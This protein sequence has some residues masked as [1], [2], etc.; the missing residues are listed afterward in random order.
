MA[1]RNKAH[2]SLALI[3]A[4]T[5]AL[6]AFGGSALAE[7]DQTLDDYEEIIGTY[8]IDDSIPSYETYVGRH[9]GAFPDEEI[10]IE[11]KDY[12]RYLDGTTDASGNDVEAIPEI[13]TN[14]EPDPDNEA[15]VSG[16]AV[17]T[18]EQ[19]LI[20][21]EVTINKTG[22]YYLSVNYIPV[23]GASA[24][25]QRA[26]FIDGEL[27]Y[28][29]CASVEFDRVYQCEIKDGYTD[30][31]GVEL[32][33]WEADNQGNDLKPALIETPE[34]IDSYLYDSEGYVT[35]EL[36]F[37]LEAGTHTITVVALRE[38][39]M[40]RQMKLG[41][42]D[43]VPT[44]AEK[45]KEWEAAGA[46]DAS[47]QTIRI[48]AENATKTSSQM[49][50][51]VQD[52]SS[53]A[54]YPS[55]A[56]E[57]KNNS[58]GGNSWRLTGQWI[59]WE[60]DVEQ[61]GFYNIQLFDKQNFVR[62][63]YVSRKITIDGEVP[64]EEFSDYGFTYAQSW[65]LD[66]LE[67]ENGD[68]YK[69][70]LEEGHH[71][72]RMEVVLGEFS[73]IISDVQDI[74]TDLNSVYRSVI[75]ITGVAPDADRDYQIESSLPGL[76][77][78]LIDLQE[79]L[80]DV[81]T[82][83]RAVAGK[84][85]DKE[86]VLITMRDELEELSKD[87]ER[88]SKVI[89][90]F[91]INVRACGNWIT[92]VLDQPLQLDTIY[93]TSPSSSVKV[94]HNNWWEKVLYEFKRL[95][96]SFIIDYNQ[97]GNVAD[98][99]DS[100]KPITL[101]VG[102]GRDQA[103]VIKDMIDESFT[104]TTGI[105]VN[106]MLV[107]VSTLLQATLA[108]QGPDVAI[109]VAND[110]PLNYGIRNAVYDLSEFDDLNEI[111][112]RFDSSA[113]RAFQ[114]NGSTYALPE[115]QTYLMMFYRKDILKEIGMDI[116]QTWD[117]VNVA[118]AKLSQNQMEFG[119]LPQEQV[120]SMILYQN[121]GEYYNEDGSLCILDEDEGINAFKQYCAFYTDY[122][123]DKETSVEERFRTG[124]CP[125]IISDISTYNNLQVSAPDIKGLWG[126]AAVPGTVEEDGTINRSEG[127]GGTACVIMSKTNDPDGCW[128]FLK[129]W[130]STDVQVQFSREMESLMGAS[131]RVAT[132]NTEAFVQLDWPVSDLETL[133]EQRE[134]LLG[135]PQVPGSYFTW[136]NINN[137]FY[138]VT[139]E[140]DTVSPR[141]ELMDKILL[142]NE[143]IAFK[144][145]EFELD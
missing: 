9:D 92:Q 14:Y 143:E 43:Q 36:G 86:T 21:Y 54:V 26:F 99:T 71:T 78:Q 52:Q 134:N 51:P 46:A 83:L 97:V 101:W 53:P 38:P 118:M 28:Q 31:N 73:D 96:Y 1:K 84:N 68:P 141:E 112:E 106:V 85:S 124:E 76:A 119:M 29:E 16:D 56:K 62:G 25:I 60:F 30:Q 142:I 93:I 127:S 123:L 122:S 94:S 3:L 2:K 107:D 69:I 126:M 115:T 58:I 18:N 81:I 72:I 15:Y 59:E 135:I 47:A 139:T 63:I 144:R 140:T 138:S 103:N 117:D 82:R 42:L 61:T 10:I 27:P 39:M 5:M 37:Y 128:E 74:V 121:H 19:G 50:Y 35:S 34:W 89:G 66:T 145:A 4:G 102:T 80:D 100:S 12:V 91:K 32:L 125:I 44:Y 75:R 57:L 33:N 88:F 137:A 11:A 79:R 108:G 87:V 120:F 90:T 110:M 70:Y 111:L 7:T 131:A 23:E 6:S 77:D 24:S 116:P 130:T 55:S 48:E 95:F 17:Y 105:N 49:L 67:D 8:N 109:Q 64:F 41:Q 114:F 22:W 20:E 136:R 132:A 133:L 98:S 113:Y 104:N 13:F 65:R 129:W 45:L 40:L